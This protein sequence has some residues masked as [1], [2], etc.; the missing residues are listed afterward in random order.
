MLHAAE[1]FRT[2][3]ECGQFGISVT[4]AKMDFQKLL[5]YRNSTV[6]QLVQGVEQL[7]SANGVEALRGRGTLLPDRQVRVSF[8][9]GDTS[10]SAEYVLLATG[11]RPK[12][13]PIL[14]MEL[15]GV[16]DSDGLFA[17]EEL[18]EQIIIIGGGAIGVELAGAFSD[19][20]TD[21][22]LLEA[23]PR[24]LPGMDRD[25][26]QNLRMILHR[27]DVELHLGAKL[28]EIRRDGG[29]LVCTFEEKGQEKETHAPYVLCAAGREPN[30]DGLF[31]RGVEL[32]LNGGFLTVDDTFQTSL[33]GVYA[34]GDLI[35]GPQLAHAAAA[36]GMVVAE[37]LAGKEPSVDLAVIP[38]CVYTRPEIASVGLTEEEAKAQGLQVQ[39]GKFLMGANGRSV[40]SREERGFI[41]IISEEG[42]GQILGAQL[43]CARA[44]DL[45]GE[46]TT[47]TANHMTVPQ[48][49]RTM[50]AHPTYGEGI[51]EALEDLAG[52]AIHAVP[53]G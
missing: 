2:I 12:R 21:V 35:R 51:G 42:S 19:L 24:L 46:L 27:R 37:R 33:K 44:T 18:P 45:I 43:M 31:A 23:Q 3:Q 15:P 47:A 1:L 49:L 30:V 7:L 11:S 52:G 34:V 8:L 17:L 10:L 29:E 53:R 32:E 41:K 20:G 50:R 25:I 28:R 6:E 26:S 48:L 5:E 40:I 36:Q 14:G 13:L 4:G 9:G 16:L 38:R 22:T 39:I